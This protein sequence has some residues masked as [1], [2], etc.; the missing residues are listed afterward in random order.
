MFGGAVELDLAMTDSR[1]A[2]L[3]PATWKKPVLRA[4]GDI[5]MTTAGSAGNLGDC[6][7]QRSS[8]GKPPC[9]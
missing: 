2:P 5:R 3:V 7:T 4:H 1:K 8:T 6:G 9:T